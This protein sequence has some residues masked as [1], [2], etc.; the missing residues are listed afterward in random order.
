MKSKS[1]FI[2]KIL[3]VLDLKSVQESWGKFNLY[4][5]RGGSLRSGYG[6]DTYTRVF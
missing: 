4:F 5:M 1:E 2:L 3:E 6:R